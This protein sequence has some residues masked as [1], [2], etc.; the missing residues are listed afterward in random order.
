MSAHPGARHAH[1]GRNEEGEPP[2][3]SEVTPL[4]V[5]PAAR[6]EGVGGWEEA[7]CWARAT[8]H[9]G[10]KPQAASAP[11]APVSACP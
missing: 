3:L 2:K 10:R 5:V 4:A 9:C 6:G 7:W 11:H 1:T 8:D